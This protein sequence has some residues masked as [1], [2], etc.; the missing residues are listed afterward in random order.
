MRVASLFV[1]ALV[2]AWAGTAAAQTIEPISYSPEFQSELEDELGVR[3][4]AYL[5]ETLTRYV[6]AAFARRGVTPEAN[7]RLELS[8]VDARPNRP[9]MQQSRDTPSLDSFRSV[10]IGGAE[11][12][13]VLRGA[14]GAVLAE[15]EHRHYSFDIED[16]ARS[17]GTWA[18]A[19]QAMRR[20]AD[21][22]ADAYV[23]HAG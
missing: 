3:E 2:L 13:G 9:T 23:A 18:D 10:S 8:I 4:G 11:L 1:S 7:V 12:R 19:R 15:V 17:A 6:A 20:F 22:L 14:D 21:K 16:A 5:N